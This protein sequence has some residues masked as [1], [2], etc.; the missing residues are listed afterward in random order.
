MKKIAS[1]EIDHTNYPA[2]IYLSRTDDNIYT[3]DVR[4]CKPYIDPLLTNAQLHSLEHVLATL[5]RNSEYSS[6]VIYVG[7][8][9][10]QTGFYIILKDIDYMMAASIIKKA[11]NDTINFDQDM[12]GKSK[13]ECG[14]YKNL[15]LQAAKTVATLFLSRCK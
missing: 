9:G 8:M 7:P 10:C 15:S 4:I 11:F 5:L 14:N 1:F 2:G 6:N 13:I 3:Y 12:P